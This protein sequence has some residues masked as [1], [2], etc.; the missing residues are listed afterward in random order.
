LKIH[1]WG[2]D[3]P[4]YLYIDKVLHFEIVVPILAFKQY[5][6]DTRITKIEVVDSRNYK[7][8]GTTYINWLSILR[9]IND[10]TVYKMKKNVRDEEYNDNSYYLPFYDEEVVL[11]LDLQKFN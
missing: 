9:T 6:I 4:Q 11:N 3:V 1:F 5:L 8:I 2:L 7:C 10:Q